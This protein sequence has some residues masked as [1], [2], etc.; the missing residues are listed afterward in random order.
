MFLDNITIVVLIPPATILICEL[1]GINTIPMPIEDALL[2]NTGG[3]GTIVGDPPNIMI[4]AAALF[5]KWPA[6]KVCPRQSSHRL[7]AQAGR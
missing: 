1:L 6:V 3:T 5:S 4:G 2:S 7:F